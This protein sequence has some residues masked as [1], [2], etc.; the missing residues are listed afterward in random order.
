MVASCY[1]AQDRPAP[2]ELRR[3]A[4]EASSEETLEALMSAHFTGYT[5]VPDATR[6]KQI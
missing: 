6:C 2:E 3:L 1:M 5:E 4:D